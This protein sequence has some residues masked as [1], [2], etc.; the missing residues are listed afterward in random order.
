MT[1]FTCI[2]SCRW[3]FFHRSWMFFGAVIFMVDCFLNPYS[4]DYSRFWNVCQVVVTDLEILWG[5]DNS[6]ANVLRL[7][8]PQTFS[9][10]QQHSTTFISTF[11]SFPQFPQF[12]LYLWKTLAENDHNCFSKSDTN[13]GELFLDCC[14][15]G[16]LTFGFH[17]LHP[18]SLQDNKWH[19]LS[20]FDVMPLDHSSHTH[21]HK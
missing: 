7:Q 15:C 11:I 19:R 21:A 8:F 10:D 2:C 20:L 5:V 17:V 14:T 4:V 1:S 12:V 18:S 16:K 3:Y 13:V 6:I 9:L